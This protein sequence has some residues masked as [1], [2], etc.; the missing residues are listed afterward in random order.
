MRDFD[1]VECAH[2]IL[3]T[4]LLDEDLT[5]LVFGDNRREIDKACIRA[6]ALCWML[7]HPHV[8]GFEMEL[9]RV[10]AQLADLG[11]EVLDGRD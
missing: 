7:D 6:D 5:R 4:I 9:K 3:V 1:D 8:T 10:A 11:M 2:D